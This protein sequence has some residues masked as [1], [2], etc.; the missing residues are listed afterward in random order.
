MLRLQSGEPALL[1]KSDL[2]EVAAALP[3][4]QG[5]PP[6]AIVG[7]KRL[8][9]LTLIGEALQVDVKQ[10]RPAQALAALREFDLPVGDAP[11]PVTD[12][13]SLNDDNAGFRSEFDPM[14]DR[15][16]RR[17]RGRWVAVQSGAVLADASD[18]TT[19]LR[20]TGERSAT[21]LFVPRNGAINSMPDGV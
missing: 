6:F 8:P 11:T 13:V 9:A 3:D 7:G 2:L 14:L 21:V 5:D 20:E 15:A 18:L 10:L 19:L 12:T 1:K 17:L 16:L 4:G